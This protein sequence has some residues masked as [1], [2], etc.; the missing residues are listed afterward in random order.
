MSIMLCDGCGEQIDTDYKP[1]YY[2]VKIGYITMN[3]CERC[4]ILLGLE[5]DE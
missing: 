3:L 5:D 4:Y 2:D 1:F